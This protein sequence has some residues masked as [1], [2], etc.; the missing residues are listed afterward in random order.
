MELERN[1]EEQIFFYRIRFREKGQE[2]TAS[3]EL[4]DLKAQ[5][6]VMVKTDHGAEPAIIISRAPSCHGCEKNRRASY[7]LVRSANQEEMGRYETITIWEETAFRSCKLLVEQHK[8]PMR[9]VRAERYFNGSKIVFYFTANNRID[10]RDLVKD[11]VLEFHTRVEMRQVGVRH[12]TKMIGGLGT[13]GRELCCSV[14]MDKFDSV[15]IKMAKEQDLPLNPT[16]ISGVCNRLLCCLTYEYSTYRRERK[17][18]PKPGKRIKIGE[19]IFQVRRQ[20][21]LQQTILVSDSQGDS[22]LLTKEQWQDCEPVKVE[23]S[24]KKEKK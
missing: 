22:H 3:S 5:D 14:F 1:E 4:P 12:E 8:L 15:S 24:G 21:P 6:A 19:D 16:K 23:E 18:M 10:F 7:A 9:L 11:L 2:F 13:C 20:H 17:G